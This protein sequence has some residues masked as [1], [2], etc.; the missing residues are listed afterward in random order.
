PITA[1]AIRL[2]MLKLGPFCGGAAIPL[3]AAG[4]DAATIAALTTQ[5][6]AL[7]RVAGAMDTAF[8]AKR[9]LPVEADVNARISQLTDRLI[10]IFGQGFVM[11][12][13]IKLVSTAASELTSATAGSTMALGG[14]ALAA[15]SWAQRYARV[16]DTI[17]RF[18]STL[19]GAE[20]LA[21]GE[22]LNLSVAQL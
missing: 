11:L 8:L 3:N 17:A 15:N 19:R 7:L 9:A 22:K 20:V 10:G 4:E 1:E 5:A 2:A 21:T 6:N 12:P 14:D 13:H 18:A 16:R